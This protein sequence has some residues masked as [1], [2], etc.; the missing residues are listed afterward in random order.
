MKKTYILLLITTLLFFT[1]CEDKKPD[2]NT[3]IEEKIVKEK[4]LAQKEAQIRQK[5]TFLLQDNNDS[6]LSIYVNNKHIE[7]STVK[8]EIVILNFFATWCKPCRGE[9]PYIADLNHKYDN[10]IFVAGILVN[11]TVSKEDLEI[12][13]KDLGVN[14]FM[15]SSS[16]NDDFSKLIVEKLKLKGNFTL[17]LT[18]LFKSGKYYSHYEGAVPMEMLNHDIKNAMS[19]E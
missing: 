6:N 3:K 16:Q 13:K 8:Q 1:G 9:I 10:K 2:E 17:P 19:K 4:T 15:S 11:D 7:I 18:I 5:N 12:Y 14:Y